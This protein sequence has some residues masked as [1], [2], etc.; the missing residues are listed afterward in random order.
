MASAGPT[1]CCRVLVDAALHRGLYSLA[2]VRGL[3]LLRR[4][5][6][7][8]RS[9]SGL[10][11]LRRRA[12][13]R[14]SHSGL[15]LPRGSSGALRRLRPSESSRR[16]PHLREVTP[17][18]RPPNPP[19][20]FRTSGMLRRGAGPRILPEVSE[21]PGGYEQERAQRTGPSGK[22][23]PHRPRNRPRHRDSLRVAAAGPWSAC[24]DSNPPGGF[25]A[26]GRLRAGA[27]ATRGAVGQG[28]KQSTLTV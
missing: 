5:A 8:R 14:R 6:R 26:S 27:S 21:P 17:R 28:A 24:A 25:R 20:G 18:S 2:P 1:V 10:G 4:R 22:R 7:S 23:S 19:G 3:G 15:R 13:S 11:L 16:F 12:H 9:H